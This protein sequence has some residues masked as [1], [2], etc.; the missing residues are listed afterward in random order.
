MFAQGRAIERPLTHAYEVTMTVQRTHHAR[1]A[2]PSHPAAHAA[3]KWLAGLEKLVK[4]QADNLDAY[5]R[6]GPDSAAPGSA[7]AKSA[8][9]TMPKSLRDFFA[10]QELAQRDND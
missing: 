6:V 9:A 5:Q 1:P 4:E 10:K 3:P 7:K 8:L 2:A